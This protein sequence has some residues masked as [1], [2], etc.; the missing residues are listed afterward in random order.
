MGTATQNGNMLQAKGSIGGQQTHGI[1]ADRIEG[2]ETQIKQAREAEC[3]IEA[4]SHQDVQ[5]DDH[6]HL[7]DEWTGDL[8]QSKGNIKRSRRIESLAG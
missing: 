6:D 3:D 2:H 7:R 5:A 1:G 4:E 8:R